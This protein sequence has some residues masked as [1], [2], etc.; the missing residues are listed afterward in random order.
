MSKKYNLLAAFFLLLLFLICTRFVTPVLLS[1]FIAQEFRHKQ[2]WLCEV[3][4]T[5]VLVQCTYMARVITD[6][7]YLESFLH[8]FAE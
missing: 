2:I 4:V 5:K 3:P 6:H 8:L 1:A 7:V